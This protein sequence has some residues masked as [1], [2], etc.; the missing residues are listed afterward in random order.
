MLSSLGSALLYIAH[1]LTMM[2]RSKKR[3]KKKIR[4]RKKKKRK[5]KNKIP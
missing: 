5:R 2:V 4:S 3:E 1:V